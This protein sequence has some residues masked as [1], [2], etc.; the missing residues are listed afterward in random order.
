[1]PRSTALRP[2]QS[3]PLVRTPMR[4]PGMILEGV[5]G[6]HG[7]ALRRP[8]VV[9]TP[10]AADERQSLALSVGRAEQ[11]DDDAARRG[12][13]GVS[14]ANHLGHMLGGEDDAFPRTGGATRLDAVD[15]VGPEQGV[16]VV[17]DDPQRRG[18]PLHADLAGF[19]GDI[20][21]KARLGVAVAREAGQIGRGGAGFGR[22]FRG[23][24]AVGIE[25]EGAAHPQLPGQRVH[26]GDG[27]SHRVE[28]RGIGQ[29]A[30][31]MVRE[32]HRGHIVRGEKAGVDQV[33]QRHHVARL[34]A[35]GID[36]ARRGE[37]RLGNS[38]RPVKIPPSE[39]RPI[40]HHHREG[41][42]RE[43][44]DGNLLVFMFPAQDPAGLVVD[45]DPAFR[46]QTSGAQNAENRDEENLWDA[47]HE[48][49]LDTPN[50]MFLQSGS[51]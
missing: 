27:V 24:Q 30:A 29:D 36:A 46:P 12:Q 40:E 22:S 31:E 37:G 18:A 7:A 15:V 21:G 6:L 43:A 49:Y 10:A 3:P 42:L 39:F 20:E 19:L 32:R 4:F 38:R 41:Q 50:R 33:A 35:E 17:Q 44:R 2:G 14:P 28:T 26:L 34:Q 23:V 8:V 25:E 16:G 48:A 51:G 47:R 5:G 45:G 13:D 1:M 11:N 9:E